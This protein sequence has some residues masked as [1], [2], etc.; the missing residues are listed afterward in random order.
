MAESRLTTRGRTTVP[1][2][3]R[4]ALGLTPGTRLVWHVMPEDEVLLLAKSK[5]V[6]ELAGTPESPVKGVNIEDMKAWRRHCA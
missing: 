4:Q 5:S 1:A 2:Q 6:L 3:D